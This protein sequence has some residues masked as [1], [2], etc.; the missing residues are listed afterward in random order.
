MLSDDGVINIP[1]YAPHRSGQ[2][3]MP[4]AIKTSQ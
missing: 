1:C 3:A 4:C 2:V